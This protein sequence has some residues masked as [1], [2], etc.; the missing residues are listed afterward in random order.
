MLA[1]RMI[2][3]RRGKLSVCRR[4]RVTG[5]GRA[6]TPDD[7]RARPSGAGRA[8]EAS[9]LS[10]DEELGTGIVAP[11]NSDITREGDAAP[12]P[13]HGMPAG[14]ETSK[15]PCFV[16]YILPC[17]PASFLVDAVCPVAPCHAE[18][19]GV[20]FLRHKKHLVYTHLRMVY[21]MMPTTL[22]FLLPPQTGI[23]MWCWYVTDNQ[24][25]GASSLTCPLLLLAY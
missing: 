2:D 17:T 23:I 16:F 18:A 9:P 25:C 1:Q 10:A 21:N 24:F 8:G 22:D 12:A 15:V 7:G 20:V 14:L 5:D 13:T 4:L 3:S 11:R 19:K 6:R